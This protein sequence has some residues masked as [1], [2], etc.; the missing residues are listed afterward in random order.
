MTALCWGDH[1]GTAKAIEKVRLTIIWLPL[2]HH[3]RQYSF[4]IVAGSVRVCYH[5]FKLLPVKNVR[6]R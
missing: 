1:G 6:P 2:S 4:H 5:M 3:D